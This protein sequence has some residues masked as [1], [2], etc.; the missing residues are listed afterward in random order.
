MSPLVLQMVVG[1]GVIAAVG[2]VGLLL[3]KNPASVAEQRLEGI[4][5]GRKGKASADLSTSMLLRPPTIDQGAGGL[6]KLLPTPESLAQLFEQADV[7]IPFSRFLLVPIGMACMGA[8]LGMV[9]R[10]PIWATPL[11]ALF[12]G[13]IPFLWLKM[14]K[15]KRVRMFTLQMPEALELT[16]RALRAGHGL[17][18]GLHCVAEEMPPP[19]A[20][21]FS[22][23]Y[24][25]QNLGIPLEEAL[26]GLADRVPSMDVKFFVT[27]VV[28]QRATG[29]DLAE[30]L[31]KI[32]HLIRE[33][34]QI[35]G[36]VAALTAEGRL[37]GILLMAL[38][39]GLMAVIHVLNPTYLRPLFDT[40]MG[41]KM[42]AAAAIMQLIG[43][44]AI[45]KIADD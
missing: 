12:M 10:I 21:E 18:S 2:A 38:P 28:I 20:Y 42:L 25:E 31:D 4:G 26:R 40:P 27:A 9:G 39:P 6:L 33:R 5:K 1:L 16:G 23:V 37:S 24:E 30:V 13:W 11:S 14:R 7:S 32:S 3:T 43:A 19:I 41:T 8:V 44:V 29:G 45:K 17:A 34:F 22:R 15:N 35:M 36:Q